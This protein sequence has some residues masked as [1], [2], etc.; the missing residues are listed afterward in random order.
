MK[1]LYKSLKIL[2]ALLLACFIFESCASRYSSNGRYRPRKNKNCTCPAYSRNTI[3]NTVVFPI[4]T[5]QKKS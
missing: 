3:Q 1:S 2:L 5:E 4:Q